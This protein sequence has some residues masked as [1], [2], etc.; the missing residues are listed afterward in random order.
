MLRKKGLKK[1]LFIAIGVILISSLFMVCDKSSSSLAS[2]I[3]KVVDLAGRT[4][5]IPKTVNR[6]VC[7]GP[8]ALRLICYMNEE[9]K[10]VG[11]E[12]AEKKW[13]PTGRPYMLANP[14][15]ANLPPIGPGGPGAIPIWRKGK[16]MIIKK[17]CTFLL[18]CFH[19]VS[20]QHLS[21]KR[22]SIRSGS[23][24]KF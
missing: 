7:S 17:K 16:Q 24:G 2:T 18:S 14:K 22:F 12:Q 5:E 1:I 23:S 10:V 21:L 15:L 11:V 3:K 20:L 13:G 9:G 6:I 19:T 8:G 4:V